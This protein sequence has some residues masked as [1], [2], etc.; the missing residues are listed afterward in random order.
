MSQKQIVEKWLNDVPDLA[1]AYG[2]RKIFL[3]SYR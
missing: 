1:T 2:S 3:T